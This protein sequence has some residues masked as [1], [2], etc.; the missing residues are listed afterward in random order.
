VLH[1]DFGHECRI[2]RC[3]LANDFRMSVEELASAG[4]RFALG[5]LYINFDKIWYGEPL[6]QPVESHRRHQ[7]SVP[8]TSRLACTKAIKVI[9]GTIP[10][11]NVESSYPKT[12]CDR[13]WNYLNRPVAVVCAF[14]AL[15]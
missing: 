7:M 2:S 9:S 10:C 12:V 11:R 15:K 3:D 8:H 1:Q 13:R 6:S 14:S 4:K 5:F